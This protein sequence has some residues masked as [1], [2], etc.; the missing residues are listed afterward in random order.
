MNRG[1]GEGRYVSKLEGAEGSTGHH[2]E[3]REPRAV[4]VLPLPP[5]ACPPRASHFAVPLPRY[6][7]APPLF[8]GASHPHPPPSLGVLHP[9]LQIGGYQ[10]GLQVLLSGLSQPRGSTAKLSWSLA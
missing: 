4:S 5:P 9:T 6:T 2:K 7:A 1:L 10:G 3:Q 8:S